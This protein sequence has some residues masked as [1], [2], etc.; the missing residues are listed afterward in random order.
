M[1]ALTGSKADSW[2]PSLGDIEL[3]ELAAA[4]ARIDDAADGELV[5]TERGRG[6]Y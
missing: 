6:F 4:N 3:D 5:E 2:L 1:L